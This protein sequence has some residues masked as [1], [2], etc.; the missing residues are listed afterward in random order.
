MEKCA[1]EKNLCQGA[2]IVAGKTGESGDICGRNLKKSTTME[3]MTIESNAY[4]LLVEKIEKIT[5]YVE[6]SRNREETERKRKEEAESPVTKD[7]K[8]TRSG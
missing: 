5:A 1:S 3:I 4:R 6:E 2:G 7:G 8:P